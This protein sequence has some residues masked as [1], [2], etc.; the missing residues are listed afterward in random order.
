MKELKVIQS[1]T[2]PK[3]TSVLWLSPEG[4]KRFTS[5]G[6]EVISGS[7]SGSGSVDTKKYDSDFNNDF[8]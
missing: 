5:K 3:Q 4:L 6:W 7:N 1:I 8:A 2:E